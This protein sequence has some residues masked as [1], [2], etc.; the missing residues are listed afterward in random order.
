MSKRR[1]SRTGPRRL[2]GWL[3]AVSW[4]GLLLGALS[5]VTWRQ[6]RGLELEGELREVGAQREM[7]EAERVEL[8]RRIEVLRSRSR[9]LEVA[10]ERLGMRLP[11]TNEIIFLPATVDSGPRTLE[12]AR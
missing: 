10:R 12:R 3:L 11:E 8:V 2:P 5:L 6:T 4:L 9:I 1:R 7:A